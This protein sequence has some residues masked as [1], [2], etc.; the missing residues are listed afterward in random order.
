MKKNYPKALPDF[1]LT[2]THRKLLRHAKR[3]LR[4]GSGVYVCSS[5]QNGVSFPHLSGISCTPEEADRAQR[6]LRRFVR[7]AID[8]L[9]YLESWQISKGIARAQDGRNDDRIEWIKY[10]LKNA[11]WE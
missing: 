5:I 11:S 6:D 4:S 3:R 1:V 8:G 7:R 9:S 10:I 2:K